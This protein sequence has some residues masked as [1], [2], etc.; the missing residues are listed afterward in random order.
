M[1]T[2]K[3]RKAN[4]PWKGLKPFRGYVN[5]VESPEVRKANN[6][7]KGL[8]LIHLNGSGFGRFRQ[9]G[10]Q[11][12]EGFETLI[13]TFPQH[14]ETSQEGKQSLEGFETNL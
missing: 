10:K 7:W 11:S 6:P 3:V 5:P 9:E 1:K 8:K 2:K 12:L 13:Y 4:N 14:C